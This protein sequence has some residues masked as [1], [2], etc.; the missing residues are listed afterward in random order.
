[1]SNEAF[2]EINWWTWIFTIA[3]L[4][5]LMLIMRKFLYE[6][7]KKMLKERREEVEQ[8]YRSADNAK[9]EAQALKTDYERKLSETKREA[10]ELLSAASKKAQARGEEIISDAELRA[11]QLIDRAGVRIERERKSAVASA[12]EDIADMAVMAAEKIVQSSLDEQKQKQLV[13]DFI[14]GLDDADPKAW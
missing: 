13:E 7:V 10:N 5:I 3:N 12:K 2:I 9:A 4:L 14:N 1:M 6:P 8:T 11:Q